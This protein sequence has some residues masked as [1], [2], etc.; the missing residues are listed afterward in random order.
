[1]GRFNC[2]K[3]RFGRFHWGK[4]LLIFV[5]AWLLFSFFAS[6]LLFNS[7]QDFCEVK[8]GR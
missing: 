5:Q 6:R 7:C 4:I 2:L 8:A 1:M 3:Q